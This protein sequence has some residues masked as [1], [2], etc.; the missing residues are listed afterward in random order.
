[1]N[2]RK[3]LQSS[4]A[5]GL[6]FVS[7]CISAN[8]S[9][10]DDREDR[11]PL[12][13]SPASLLLPKEELDG[14]WQEENPEPEKQLYMGNPNLPIYPE[15]TV[16][17]DTDEMASYYP[18]DGDSL[19]TDAGF[20]TTAVWMYDE[21]SEAADEYAAYPH[22]EGSGFEELDIAEG[23]I[24]GHIDAPETHALVLFRDANVIGGLTYL[25]YPYPDRSIH[26]AEEL[27]EIRPGGVKSNG[28]A[29]PVERCQTQ[30][31]PQFDRSMT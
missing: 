20:V 29:P 10:D 30:S 9:D 27:A 12:E 25:N 13:G 4:V 21:I 11:P 6:A 5:L 7:G 3:P 17:S 26:S 2:R 16:Y 23:A 19:D 8:E 18:R 22:H 31:T 28:S 15:P 24:V 1:M 14:D